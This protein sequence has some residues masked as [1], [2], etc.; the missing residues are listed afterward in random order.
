LEQQSFAQDE[1]PQTLD[2][3]ICD[4]ITIAQVEVRF[5]FFNSAFSL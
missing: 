5:P 2:C 3:V 4:A 1:Y